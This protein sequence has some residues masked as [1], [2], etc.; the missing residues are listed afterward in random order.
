M[1]VLWSVKL[2]G[3]SPQRPLKTL[4]ET[5]MSAF[6]LLKASEDASDF[7]L[8]NIVIQLRGQSC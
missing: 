2:F 3:K 7:A 4:S 1:G 5:S 6:V 8:L